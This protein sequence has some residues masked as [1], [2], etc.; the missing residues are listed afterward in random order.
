MPSFTP[1]ELAVMRILW[2]QGE[3]KPSEVQQRFPEPIKNPALR[4]YLKI[5]LE[6]GHVTR[7]KV[8]KAYLYKAV[9]PRQKAFRSTLSELIETYCEGSAK[10]LVMNLIR[11]ENLSEKELLELKQLADR[12]P[13]KKGKRK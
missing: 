8:G 5:L 10:S 3:L 7:R 4:S 2:E 6:K 11:N 13:P 1:G 12:G 9:T